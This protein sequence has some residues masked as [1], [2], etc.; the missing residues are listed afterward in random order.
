MADTRNIH[1]VVVTPERQVLEQPVDAVVI[2]A[3]DGELGVLRDRAAL[4][5]E[6]GIGQ[7]RYTQA[8][9]TRRLFIDGG[10]AQV[11]DNHVT[12]LTGQALPVEDLSAEMVATANRA[13]DEHTG[14]DDESL[15]ARARAQDRLRVLRRLRV[16][17]A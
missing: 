7:L 4:M 5:C 13:V 12:V 15:Q 1:L 11:L 10:F 17:S 16:G 3:H 14:H 2:P 6:L 8:G 9:L